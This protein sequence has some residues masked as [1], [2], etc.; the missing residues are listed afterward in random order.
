MTSTAQRN[1]RSIRKVCVVTTD[2]T[3]TADC[4]YAIRTWVTTPKSFTIDKHTLDSRKGKERIS[5]MLMLLLANYVIPISEV[6]T[7]VEGSFKCQLRDKISALLKME[8][9]TSV[10]VCRFPALPHFLSSSG[11]GTGSTQ[12]L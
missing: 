1:A 6:G 10:A 2:T 12:P 7:D 5:R 4:A 9:Q 8:E 11:P 3:T